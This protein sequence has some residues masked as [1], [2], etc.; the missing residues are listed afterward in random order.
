MRTLIALLASLGCVATPS[1]GQP[2]AT[3][4]DGVRAF[5]EVDEPVV[6]LTGVRVVDGTGRPVVE[7]Q[8]IVIRDGRLD[9]VGPV[10]QIVIPTRSR[11]RGAQDRAS[12]TANPARA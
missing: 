11:R 4:S 10:D 12:I 3:L 2:A 8:T 9:A 7:D 6:A 5:V 1:L